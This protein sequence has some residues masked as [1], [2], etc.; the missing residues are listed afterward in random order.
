MGSVKTAFKEH[1]LCLVPIGKDTQGHYPPKCC[2]FL[3]VFGVGGVGGALST[4]FDICGL[5]LFIFNQFS[6]AELKRQHETSV[7]EGKVKLCRG[8]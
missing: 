6:L 5:L 1:S 7:S 8:I 2:F 4:L 3:C